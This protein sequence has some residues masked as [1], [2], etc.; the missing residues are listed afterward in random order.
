MIAEIGLPYYEL[1]TTS[2]AAREDHQNNFYTLYD[3]AMVGLRTFRCSAIRDGADSCA[4]CY[5]C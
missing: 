2:R 3:L 5:R 4:R 1:S